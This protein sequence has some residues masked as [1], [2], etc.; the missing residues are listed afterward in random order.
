[1]K[2]SKIIL[3][4]AVGSIVL[5]S[6]TNPKNAGKLKNESDSMSYAFGYNIGTSLAENMKQFPGGDSV[7][8]KDIMIAGFINALE[9]DSTHAKMTADEAMKILQDYMQK[10]QLVKMK[11]EADAYQKA[12][13]GN[14]KYMKN[15]AK[16]PGMVELKNE[17]SP[18]DPGVLL[19]VTT[20]GT[21][22]A[23]KSTD[24]VYV[25]YVGKLTDGTVFDATTG[26]EPAL[27][28]VK[29]VIPGF[30][31]ALQQLSVGSKA[32]IVIPSELAYGREAVG[33]GKVPANSILT[34]EV[35]ILKTFPNE[36]AA[37]AFAKSQRSKA[38][39]APGAPGAPGAP[40]GEPQR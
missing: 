16:E 26:K 2:L 15:K 32:T 8:N 40:A 11:D 23:I 27:F 7:V 4:A 21:G 24:F 28:P 31:Q 35:E 20:K 14:D 37:M 10:Q 30:S 6:C 33:D 5:S 12:K 13:V 17:K 9:K 1:M 3:A 39:A 19:N 36:Q 34:F 25:N 18:N 38:E 29:G 22:A